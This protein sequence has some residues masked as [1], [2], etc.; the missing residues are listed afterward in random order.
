MAKLSTNEI[1]ELAVKIVSQNPDGIRYSSLHRK[2]VELHPETPKKTIDGSIWDLDAKRSDAVEKPVRG[3]F[4]P[5]PAR[6]AVS[7]PT[8]STA[9]TRMKEEEFY[10]PFAEFLKNELGECTA[11]AP[12]GGASMK[13]KWGTPDVVGVYRP[14]KR[15]LIQFPP[16]IVAAEVKTDPSQSVT[17]FGQAVAYRLFAAKSY[18][19]LPKSIDLE[20]QDRVEAM[21]MI[22][23]L[24]LILFTLDPTAP[25]FDIRMRAQR[26][27]PDMFFVN[28]FADRLKEFDGHLFDDLFG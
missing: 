28:Q 24:G 5:I 15:D 19:V 13:L 16:E 22:L 8:E 9:K 10:Q 20:D 2:I 14:L 21:C 26:F 4:K 7:R 11:S 18:L 27:M 17:G 3:L 6:G 25:E 23:G 12:L 1:R